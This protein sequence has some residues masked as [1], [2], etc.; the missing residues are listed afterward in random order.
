MKEDE[1]KYMAENFELPL[2]EGAW[3]F[4]DAHI[5]HYPTKRR[6]LALWPYFIGGILLVGVSL[7][8]YFQNKPVKHVNAVSSA[9][10]QPFAVDA[11]ESGNNANPSDQ[12][13]GSVNQS[14]SNQVSSSSVA[15]S[16]K[17]SKTTIDLS[18]PKTNA[19]KSF[20]KSNANDDAGLSP[21]VQNA[22]SKLNNNIGTLNLSEAVVSKP[23]STASEGIETNN[24]LL[25]GNELQ[26]LKIKPFAGFGVFFKLYTSRFI[27]QYHPKVNKQVSS[28]KRSYFVAMSYGMLSSNIHLEPELMELPKGE[29]RE[30]NFY[31]GKTFSKWE[32]SLGA[33]FARIHQ[34]TSMGSHHDTTYYQVFK[35]NFETVLPSEYAGRLHDTSKLYIAGTNH[36]TAHQEFDIVGL[37]LNVGRT[38][39]ARDKFSMRLNYGA[40]YKLLKRANTFFYDSINK[41][42]VPFSQKD[43]GIVYRN[44]MS[45]R[46]SLSFNYALSKRL[47]IELAPF[48]DVFHKPFIKHYYKADLRNYGMSFG[49]RFGL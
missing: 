9:A 1:L 12:V 20:S 7:V 3:E 13:S 22:P 44:L 21:L 15:S 32:L 4:V 30:I 26:W 34:N 19:S 36:N 40:N 46:V 14:N 29:G 2:K 43:K 48:A 16:L 42:A 35:P 8:L 27:S 28:V 41:A 6:W 10:V 31:V 23:T 25:M 49:L 45:S 17:S 11:V 47:S 33:H 37:S 24:A 38:I 18:N 5:P 39:L